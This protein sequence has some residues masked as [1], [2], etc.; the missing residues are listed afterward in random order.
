MDKPVPKNPL[1]FGFFISKQHKK[2]AISALICAFIATGL[3]SFSVVIL[4]N[5]TD[6]I[7]TQPIL[8][9]SVWKWAILYPVLTFVVRNLWRGSGFMGMRWFMNFR[10]TA[11]QSLYEHLTLHS[12]DYFNSRFAGALTNKISNA[13]DGTQGLFEKALWGFIPI[14]IGLMWYVGFAF[15]SDWRLGLIISSWSILFLIINVWFAKKLQPKSYAFAQTLSTLKGKLVDSLSNI[16]LVHEYAYVGGEREYIKKYVNKARDVGLAQWQLSEWILVLNGILVFIFMLCMVGTSVYLFQNNV[17]SVGVVVMVIAI[18]ADL[19][20]QFVFIGQQIKDTAGLY[21]QAKE[22]L[23][24]ILSKHVIVDAPDAADL[25][26]T[27][28]EIEFKSIDFGYENTKV[29][30]N[31]SLV[32]PAGQK[33][34]LVGRSGAGKTTFV[35]LLLRHFDV[36]SGEVKI[37]G[38]NILNI[39][40]ES[41]RRAIAFVPQDTGLFHRT[42]RENIRYSNPKASNAQ[43]VKAAKLAQADSFI[44]QLPKGY[45]T[46]VGERGVKLSGGQRQ[47]VA[48]ARAFLKNAPILVLDEAT[49]SL[50]SQSEHAIQMSLEEL[51]KG[52][53]VIA[54]AHRLSTLKKMDRIAIIQNG[55]IVEDGSP[56]ELLLKGD[57][58]FKK[59]WDHQVKGFIIDE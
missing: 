28:G 4:R 21:G 23:E 42:I 37:G 18:V 5:L 14:L 17:V 52:R 13:V 56:E 31:F 41:L 20:H 36:Q 10:A 57:G 48:I 26:I 53:T 59:M 6:S 24:E 22:G 55:V 19:S 35:S 49:S 46:L 11:Y 27:D 38:Q 32:I 15:F 47:R 50:D 8:I 3:E 30:K 54:I 51:M 9:N 16:S 2:W 39:T 33:L 44:K 29:F 34:G 1:K 58:V 25:V 45:D 7:A 43:V 40:L 12:K